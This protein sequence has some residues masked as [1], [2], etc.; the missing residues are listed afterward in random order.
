MKVATLTTII[1]WIMVLPLVGYSQNL[2]IS[3]NRSIDEIKIDGEIKEESWCTGKPAKDFW[4]YFP[5]DSVSAQLQTEIRMTYDDKALYVAVKCYAKNDKYV[6]PSLR[7]DYQAGGN[8]NITLIFDT[9]NDQTN[10]FFFG[11]NPLGVKREGL[12]SN[13]GTKSSNF[14]TSW[15][16]KWTGKSKIYDTYWTCEMMIPFK[17]IRFKSG[18]RVWRFNSYRFDTQLNEISSL[19]RI[20]RNQGITNLAFMSDMV[21]EEP[22]KKAG[23]NIAFIPYV[24]AKAARNYSNSSNEPLEPSVG[25]D[26]KIAITSGLNL[27]LTVNPDFSQVEVDQQVTNL[28]R[29]EVFFPERRQFFL[30]N[31]DLFTSFGARRIS[32]FFSRRIGL[33]SDTSGTTI[34]NPII[35][36]AKLSGKIDN[37]W[38]VGLLNMQTGENI[39]DNLPAINYTVAAVQRKVFTRSNI[40]MIFVN[41]QATNSDSTDYDHYNRVIGMDYNFANQSNTW[42]GKAFYH[43][44]ITP[45]QDVNFKGAHGFHIHYKVNSWRA[46]MMYQYVGDGFDSQ[47]GFVPRKNFLRISPELEFYFYP[48]KTINQHSIGTDIEVLV[49][50]EEGRTD[51]ISDFFWN[52]QFQ[53][54]SQIKMLFRHNYILLT[55]EFD[56]SGLGTMPLPIN[57]DYDYYSTEIS[58]TSDRRKKFSYQVAPSYGSYFNGRRANIKGNL[59]YQFRPFGAISFNYNYNYIQLPDITSSLVLLGSRIDVTFSKKLFLTTFIQYNNQADNFNVNARLQWRF[60]PVSDFFLVYTDNYYA[61]DFQKKERAI[62][63]KF[64]YWLN[65]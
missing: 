21:W 24:K 1:S 55:D 47:V 42:F 61:S 60:Q 48:R 27:D 51:Q 39:E 40:G 19:T 50:P 3:L 7:R 5:A 58:Y 11:I 4:Q 54:S 2:P 63:A 31:A 65:L 25:A 59:T 18:S 14:S 37:D 34:E 6:I 17:T 32:P 57:S 9:F 44:A 49:Q 53:N 10:A 45:N 46:E 33:A 23:N 30:E 62:V 26:A 29:F 28:N 64:T 43:Q 16:N 13:G 52:V 15:D 8:D 35:Y 12:I 56:P 41:Q 22:L 36:G 38:R 20:P